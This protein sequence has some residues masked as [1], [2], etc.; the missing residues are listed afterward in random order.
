[1]TVPPLPRTAEVFGSTQLT[2]ILMVP[3]VPSGGVTVPLAT[4]LPGAVSQLDIRVALMIPVP[5][6]AGFASPVVAAWVVVDDGDDPA[7]VLVGEH[8][9]SAAAETSAPTKHATDF[10][11]EYIP[12]SSGDA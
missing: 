5:G 10:F 3:L 11:I 8:P 6:L 1:M 2:E 12:D 7:P 9:A 4:T